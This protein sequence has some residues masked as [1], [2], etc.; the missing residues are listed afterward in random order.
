MDRRSQILK[1]I[2][3]EQK[4]I[5]IGP[6]FAPLAPK[7]EGYN[8][9]IFD[10]FDAES[11]RKTAADD[12]F[13]DNT[14]I[15]DIDEVDIVGSSVNIASE[16]E[17]RGELGQ[18]DY[19]VSSHNIEHIP[20]PIKFLQGCEQVLRV[21]GRLSMAVPDKRACFDYFRPVSTLGSWLAAYL[22]NRNRPTLI[23]GFEQGSLHCR[24]FNDG[25]QR[26]GFSLDDDPSKIR[27]L[28]TVVEAYNDLNEKISIE[29]SKYHDTHC[30]TFTPSSFSLILLDLNL[31]G[32]T[33]LVISDTT[34]AFGNEF[35]VHLKKELAQET[36]LNDVL[37]R[38][39]ELLQNIVDECAYNSRYA[40]HLRGQIK[41]LQDELHEVIAVKKSVTWKVAG[42]LWRLETRRRRKKAR[43]SSKF[44]SD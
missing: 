6:W 40:F 37:I 32:L 17:R 21:G 26:T 13:I 25:E 42:P 16:I 10:V 41:Q 3:K 19:V 14:L 5:E 43:R 28:P 18:F 44:P 23:Q 9:L 35:H 27:N 24:F 7:K 22:E 33:K 36:D 11:L 38:R 30:W 29:D 15:K 8:C 31:I 20:N 2:T 1:Y 34:S 4:G 12:P 39:Q